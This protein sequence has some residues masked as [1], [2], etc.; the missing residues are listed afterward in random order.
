MQLLKYSQILDKIKESTFIVC[1]VKIR[2]L[3]PEIRDL[4]DGKFVFYLEN[5]EKSKSIRE[6]EKCINYFLDAGI[7]RNSEIIA[8]GGGAT[9]DLAGFI[10]ATVLRGIKWS[11]IPTT[12]LAMIDA[13]IGGKTGINSSFGKNLIGAFHQPDE[14]LISTDFLK[15]LSQDELLSG[16]GELLKYTFLSKEINTLVKEKS[17]LDEVIIACAKY[18]EQVVEEDFKESG[19]RKILNFG[20]TFGHAFEKELNI[21]HG[22]AVYY[23]I[24]FVIEYFHSELKD[25]FEQN[26]SFLELDRVKIKT[27]SFENIFNYLKFDK[28]K[29]NKND[30][31]FILLDEVGKP[32]VKI[33]NI[34]E[35]EKE[36][37]RHELFLSFFK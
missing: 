33:I 24:K 21:H 37:K 19:L 3:Y 1:D 28:K 23:G 30:V 20:H 26:S 29:V 8:I 9:S 25:E 35:L 27:S 15:T 16:K 31:E 13:S 6:Y 12:L 36:I 4:L 5:P 11:V 32:V 34:N 18:K 14:I 2:D 10:A 7:I 22:I 17:K